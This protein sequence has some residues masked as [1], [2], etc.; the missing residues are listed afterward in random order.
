MGVTIPND[1]NV[2]EHKQLERTLAACQHCFERAE[3]LTIVAVGFKV[4]YQCVA[5]ILLKF[6]T[7]LAVVPWKGV[8]DFHCRIIP[9]EHCISTVNLDEDVHAEMKIWRKGLVA[10]FG[11]EDEDCI[12]V[13]TAKVE[14]G[15]NHMSIECIPMPRESG[16]L[17][18]IYFKVSELREYRRNNFQQAFENEGSQWSTHKKIFNLTEAK[19]KTVRSLIPKGFSYV[20]VDFG[21][22]PGYAHVIE[23]DEDKFPSYFAQVVTILDHTQVNLGNNWWNPRFGTQALEKRRHG[24]KTGVE[25]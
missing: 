4:G 3:K 22:Q 19:D 7:Y 25:E 18:P 12:F 15:K 10:M 21:L 9:S 24:I 6:Q 1:L 11:A 14:S 5:H 20:A 2:S 23:K 17:A 8:G 13:E 16:D